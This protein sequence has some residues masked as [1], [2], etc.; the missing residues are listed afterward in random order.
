[1]TSMIAE[2]HRPA[3]SSVAVCSANSGSSLHASAP[4]TL[5]RGSYVSWSIRMRSIAPAVA[6]MPDEICAPSSAGPVGE[7]A[8]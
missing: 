5:K 3:M 2:P 8:A 7:D 4:I 1:M 6:R